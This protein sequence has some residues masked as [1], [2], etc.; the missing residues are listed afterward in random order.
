M[1]L[2]LLAGESHDRDGSDDTAQDDVE[3][4]PVGFYVGEEPVARKRLKLLELSEP[5]GGCP[6]PEVHLV[7]ADIEAELARVGQTVGQEHKE[8]A[9]DVLPRGM[10]SL[11]R[12]AGSWSRDVGWGWCHVGWGRGH[13][14]R[15]RGHVMWDGV[16][17]TWDGVVVM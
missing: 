16:G 7:L 8:E 17:A 13:V 15:V 4:V 14:T 10:G 3:F 11:S 12:D 9:T 1:H 5:P 6:A 2:G